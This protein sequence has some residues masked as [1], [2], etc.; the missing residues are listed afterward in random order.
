MGCTELMAD[1]GSAQRYRMRVID[2]AKEFHKPILLDQVKFDTILEEANHMARS[3][4]T[5]GE[6]C[7]IRD[8]SHTEGGYVQFTMPLMWS[9][10]EYARALL[11]RANDWWKMH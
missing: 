5:T 6:R 7:M 10:V 2:F 4:H 9:H 8:T 1:D 3:Y 11:V